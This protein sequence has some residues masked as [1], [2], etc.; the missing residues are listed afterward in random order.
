MTQ[1]TLREIAEKAVEIAHA[2]PDHVANLPRYFEDQ[3]D[4]NGD[5]ID[6]PQ[7]EPICLFGNALSCLGFGPSVIE[8]D[9]DIIGVLDALGYE[10]VVDD[11]PVEDGDLTG[12]DPLVAGMKRAQ[13]AQDRR[14]PWG[15]AIRDLESTLGAYDPHGDSKH[16]VYEEN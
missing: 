13:E 8:E 11:S 15:E 14:E 16:R 2:D 5:L 7:A 10:T 3:H 4:E 6:D 1:P 9:V 12:L